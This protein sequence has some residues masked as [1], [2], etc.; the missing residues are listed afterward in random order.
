MLEPGAPSARP[1][2]HEERA[3]AGGALPSCRS[4]AK[5]AKKRGLIPSFPSLSLHSALSHAP[6][7]AASYP[8]CRRR[9]PTPRAQTGRRSAAASCSCGAHRHVRRESPDRRG[10]LSLPILGKACIEEAGRVSSSSIP[11]LARA[12]SSPRASG[13]RYPWSTRR[14]PARGVEAG[15]LK[16]FRAGGL[17][18]AG[19]SAAGRSG[20]HERVLRTRRARRR[21]GRR[22]RI[23]GRCRRSR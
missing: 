17:A 22:R 14:T 13:C 19:G 2:P 23:E 7:G 1:G 16:A 11:G 4:L 5:S 12:S 21:R 20:Q 3:P 10:S 15:G 6:A 9:T 8:R 18:A